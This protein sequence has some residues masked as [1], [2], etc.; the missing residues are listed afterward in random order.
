MITKQELIVSALPH[1]ERLDFVQWDRW[2]DVYDEAKIV[3]FYGWITRR[4][5]Q[6]KDFVHLEFFAAEKGYQIAYTTSSSEKTDEI[7]KILGM[8]ESHQEC[9]RV[10]KLFPKLKNTI[11]LPK[12]YTPGAN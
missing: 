4:H 9:K 2:I 8:G 7:G 1:L 11:K 5:D 10:E 6:Y 12:I 3:I